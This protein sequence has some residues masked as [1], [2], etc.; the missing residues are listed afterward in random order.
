MERLPLSPDAGKTEATPE[1]IAGWIDRHSAKA[2][3]L[4]CR[5]DEM[6]E[7]EAEIFKVAAYHLGFI[8]YLRSTLPNR[9]ETTMNDDGSMTVL[10]DPANAFSGPFE[11]VPILPDH[12]R[13]M[14]Q[15]RENEGPMFE[16]SAPINFLHDGLEMPTDGIWHSS[17]KQKD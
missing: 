10:L 2:P 16:Y 4:P 17:E 7:R 1:Q 11:G 6:T 12:W 8:Q 3:L 14:L 5:V 13:K 9:G 15:N